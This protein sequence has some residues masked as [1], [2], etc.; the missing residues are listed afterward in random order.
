[1]SVTQSSSKPATSVNPF[2]LLSGL[3]SKTE[4]KPSTVTSSGNGDALQMLAGLMKSVKT[5]VSSEEAP[6]STAAETLPS[7]V[8]PSFSKP[9]TPPTATETQSIHTEKAPLNKETSTT[10]V[11][12]AENIKLEPTATPGNS[13]AV[14]VKKEPTEFVKKISTIGSAGN[15]R[16]TAGRH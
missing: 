15:N 9:A 13:A 8:E 2:D 6:P 4:S 14:E 7:K 10:A 3:I 11:S 1:M 12:G 16:Y 5:P